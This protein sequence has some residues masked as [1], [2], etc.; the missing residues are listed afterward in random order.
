M[1]GD[2][3]ALRSWL[4]ILHSPEVQRDEERWSGLTGGEPEAKDQCSF[5]PQF[6][7]FVGWTRPTERWGLRLRGGEMAHQLRVQ[8]RRPI[9]PLV[10]PNPELQAVDRV[11][12]QH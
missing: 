2:I 8:R 10:N 1:T 3:A 11:R 5:S 4:V 12:S 6:V 7:E 9:R